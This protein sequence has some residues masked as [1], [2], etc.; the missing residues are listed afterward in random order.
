MVT[1]KIE[2]SSS[3]QFGVEVLSKDHDRKRFQSGNEVLD[4]YLKQIASQDVK[5]GLAVAY[6][7]VA[8]ND[9]QTILGFYTLSCNSIKFDA[10]PEGAGKKLPSNRRIPVILL[11]QLAIDQSAQGQGLG[12]RLLTEAI[13]ATTEASK[14]FGIYALI[15]DALDE[16][17][18]KFYTRVGFSRLRKY[19]CRL[20]FPLRKS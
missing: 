9:P 11:G 5:R 16:E 13:K 1:G 8:K 20:F 14:Q 10:L 19:E 7:L 3:G 18:E 2:G 4:K 6:V 17:V 12:Q 15:V